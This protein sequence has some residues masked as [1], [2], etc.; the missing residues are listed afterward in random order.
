MTPV[1]RKG[2]LPSCTCSGSCSRPWILEAG[3]GMGTRT[4]T[5]TGTGTGTPIPTRT[6]TGRAQA[7]AQSWGHAH[8]RRDTPAANQRVYLL[9]TTPCPQG[10]LFS[11]LF[12]AWHTHLATTRPGSTTKA[13]QLAMA[14]SV[15][16]P[17]AAGAEPGVQPG[18]GAVAV[19]RC[20][21]EGLH[22][23]EAAHIARIS[24]PPPSLCL[25]VWG[26]STHRLLCWV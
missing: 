7:R 21:R 8:A 25:S 23:S 15:S 26:A 12:G 11:S 14:K 3:T 22:Y 9:Y 16:R 1:Q 18:V 17:K 24:T 6:R 13:S 2:V 10:G 5:G 4:G 20:T 19:C